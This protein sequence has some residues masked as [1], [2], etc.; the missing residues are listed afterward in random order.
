MP[1]YPYR[2]IGVSLNR[3]FRNDQ[4]QNLID[5]AADIADQDGKASQIDSESKQ[6]DQLINGRVDNL[7]INGT[8]DSNPEVVDARVDT[9]GTTHTVLKERLDD[10][11]NNTAAQ[12]A[13]KAQL[14]NDV[15]N[16]FNLKYKNSLE[17]TWSRLKHISMVLDSIGHGAGS[18]V[19]YEYSWAGILRKFFQ[20][21]FN[22][23]NHGYVNLSLPEATQGVFD[24][25][26]IEA[27][28]T[29]SWI[30]HNPDGSYIGGFAYESSAA[31]DKLS[32][33]VKKSSLILRLFYEVAADG[34]QVDI[35]LNGTTVKTIDTTQGTVAKYNMSDDIDVSQYGDYYIL[36]IIKKDT[37]RTAFSGIQLVND[38][39]SMIMDN[40]GKSGLALA[41]CVDDTL[42]K[43]LDA[44]IAF[45]GLGFNDCYGRKNISG[46]TSKIDMLIPYLTQVDAQLIIL[47]FLW[48]QDPTDPY[49]QQLKR[50]ADGVPGA[51]YIPFPDIVKFSD[52]QTAINMGFLQ[53]NAH[54]T[55]KGH[56]MIA[57][58]IANILGIGISSNE[59][60]KKIQNDND[61]ISVRNLVLNSSQVYI[62]NANLTADTNAAFQLVTSVAAI[63]N[64]IKGL[65]ITV[66]FSAN[67]NI[68][69]GTDTVYGLDMKITFSDSTS[70]WVSLNNQ[71]SIN[72]GY[73]K[74]KDWQS[75]AFKG[76]VSKTFY[77]PNKT[78]TGISNTQLFVRNLAGESSVF[79]G[80]LIIYVGTKTVGYMPAPEDT[81]PL[82]PRN[83]YGNIQS[84]SVFV[85]S[86][87][88]KIKFKDGSSVIHNLQ[89][90]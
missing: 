12:L 82:I 21:E 81:V 68:N 48:W 47:D 34:G 33:F 55:P 71:R 35:Q 50:L 39:N 72:Q 16:K 63:S 30:E 90:D 25:D 58:Y 2:Q 40:Y 56:Q 6:R 88:G 69:M 11:Y 29:G 53:D 51:I 57:E 31:G 89:V 4:N 43:E 36:D 83:D 84:N 49:R 74:T 46:F 54:P 86:T 75:G 23:T 19:A 24:A 20:I 41:D 77:I 80:D 5:I 52:Q 15:Q 85:D 10:D 1:H 3:N 38:P 27:T 17:S 70:M 32:I 65:N 26:V 66:A 22:T 45:F 37:G 67:I 59:L 8:G 28:P 7:V 61:I 87:D 9:S 44:D 62:G 13:E 76:R 78:I 18:S 60:V 73:D 42:K 79:F 64:A 14:Q